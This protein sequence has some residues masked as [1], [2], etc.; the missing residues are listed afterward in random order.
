MKKLILTA[1]VLLGLALTSAFGDGFKIYGVI[2]NADIN[3]RTITLDSSV[4]PGAVLRILPNTEIDMDDC[5]LFG[6]YD[7][8]GK[9]ED[10]VP[11]TFVKAEVF[12]YANPST[13]PTPLSVK[14]ITIECGKKAY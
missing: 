9:W 4:S 8:H 7:K 12:G 11:G 13:S 3:T 2:T 1:S 14:E 6:L 5:G 10:L